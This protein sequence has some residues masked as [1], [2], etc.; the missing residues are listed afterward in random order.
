MWILLVLEVKQ[1]NT[2]VELEKTVLHC[3]SSSSWI[4]RSIEFEIL[5]SIQAIE[6]ISIYK[7]FI[8]MENILH[9]FLP[10]NV[11]QPPISPVF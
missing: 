6:R 11:S 9:C 2:N 10:T 8:I 3:F 7:R 5:P 4:L 1:N